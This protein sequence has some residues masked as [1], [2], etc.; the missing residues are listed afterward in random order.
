MSVDIRLNKVD[1]V[2]RPG[3]TVS[4][5]VVV[6]SKG[7]MSHN[8]IKLT[9]DGEV[10]LQLSAKSV[11]LFEAFYNS[12]KPIKLVD[13]RIDVRKAGKVPDGVTEFAF[14][15]KLEPL[16]DESLFETYHGVFVNV[17]YV[18]QVDIPRSLLSKNLQK[19]LEFIVEVPTA[20]ARSETPVEFTITPE[21]LSNVKQT[22][23]DKIPKFKIVGVLDNA[24]C[25]INQPCTGHLVIEEA[26]SEIRS[27][28]LQL[29]RVETCGCAD[30]F[31]KEA[32]EI[33]NIQIAD[34]NVA[35]GISIPLYMVFPRLFT[36][37]TTAARTFKVEFELNLV[38]M[39]TD[40]H[41][42]SEN[43]PIKLMR[44]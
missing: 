21:Q 40:G 25:L 15:F 2:Y 9:V 37:P 8:G 4:G 27:I 10:T 18:L 14:E 11:G 17:Q 3:D 30:G 29:V 35:R 24:T 22:A 26:D 6:T 12:L 13:Y 31:A 43:F 23:V 32:T 1:R 28:E 7:G 44:V 33:Q 39:L 16:K 19:R 5:V 41:L 34:G 42:I 36:C 38:I 20:E